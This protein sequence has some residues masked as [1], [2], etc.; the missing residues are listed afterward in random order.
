[1]RKPSILLLLAL[2]LLAAIFGFIQIVSG[3]EPVQLTTPQAPFSETQDGNRREVQASG[4]LAPDQTLISFIDSPTA[5]CYQPNPAQDMCYINWY[6]MSVS[7]SPNY[8]ISM[9][10]TLNNY[11]IVADFQGFFQTSMYVPFQMNGKGFQVPCGALGDGG[12]PHLGNAYAWTIRARDST[13][14]KSANYGTAYC[15]AFQ[16]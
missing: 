12:N 13:G 1:M 6:Y 2:T 4:E 11:G 3:Q 5:S 15:P 7:A 14:L 10:A 16:P 9:T 8:I